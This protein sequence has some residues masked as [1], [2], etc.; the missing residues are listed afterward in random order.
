MTGLQPP[1]VTLPL[2][3]RKVRIDTGELLFPAIALVFCLAYY[4]DTRGLPDQSL[5]YAEPL[6]YVT[7]VLAVTTM[8]SYGITIDSGGEL[9]RESAD[10][11]SADDESGTDDASEKKPTADHTEERRTATDGTTEANGEPLDESIVTDSPDAMSTAETIPQPE[12]TEGPEVDEDVE[13]EVSGDFTLRSSIGL[14]ILSG[15]YILLLYV[16]SFVVSSILFLAAALYLLGERRPLR[17]VAYSVGF[18][19]LVWGVF[20]Q[21]LLVPLP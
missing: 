12:I 20:I 15:G 19:L 18:T 16:T 11:D 21:W 8:L 7:V 6:L 14:A 9:E 10:S 2:G 3:E 17:I 1:T 13:P 5:M 4:I